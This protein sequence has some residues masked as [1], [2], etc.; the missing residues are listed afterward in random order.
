VRALKGRDEIQYFDEVGILAGDLRIAH[1]VWLT[2]DHLE[3]LSRCRFSVVH[4][5][6][7]NLKLGSGLADVVGIRRAGIPVGLATDGAACSN[8]LDALAEIRLA[9]L[10]QQLRNGPGSLSG[11]EALRMA[12]SEGARALGLGA[13]IGS[14][15]PGKRADLLVLRGATLG[16]FAGPASDPHDR[17]VYGAT[18]SA[19][20]HVL[21]DG[22]PLVEDGRLTRIDRQEKREGAPHPS[23][24]R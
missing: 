13:E 2:G 8:S 21:V 16:L 20:R 12:T 10:L 22:R 9:A 17:V 1:G 14:I 6:S 18:R 23:T 5:P 24:T 3:R 11:L 19:V 7:S 15:E 4:C